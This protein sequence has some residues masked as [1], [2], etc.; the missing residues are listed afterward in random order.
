ML[1][2]GMRGPKT[3]LMIGEYRK[4]VAWGSV[5][6]KRSDEEATKEE[7]LKYESSIG[8]NFGSIFRNFGRNLGR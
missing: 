4:G 2:Q 6:S 3:E 7:C 8:I 1:K 5:E